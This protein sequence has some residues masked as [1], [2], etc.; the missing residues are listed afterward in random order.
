MP[1]P[2]R[3]KE[4]NSWCAGSLSI[5]SATRVVRPDKEGW[6][7]QF[8]EGRPA[9]GAGAVWHLASCSTPRSTFTLLPSALV[10]ALR[11]A[12]VAAEE[13]ADEAS[14]SIFC[15]FR[16]LAALAFDPPP[17]LP[18]S[19]MSVCATHA[20][21]R[22]TPVSAFALGRVRMPA[23]TGLCAEGGLLLEA[24]LAVRLPPTS[25]SP[26]HCPPT[27]DCEVGL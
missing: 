24:G 23:L 5:K 6:G 20:V 14:L 11:A 21:I 26:L 2:V 4:A 25:S 3:K 10:A 13:E 7:R 22:G 1:T 16:T 9:L 27:L 12:A 15:C 17:R 19:C 18:S 8:D